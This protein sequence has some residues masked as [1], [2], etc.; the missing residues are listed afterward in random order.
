MT[1][2]ECNINFPD[3]RGFI[4]EFHDGKFYHEDCWKKIINNRNGRNI[5]CPNCRTFGYTTE[6]YNGYPSGLPDSGSVYKAAY[7]KVDCKLCEG[8]GYLEK[9]PQVIIHKEYR[10]A[11]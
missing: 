8:Y 3:N 2:Q 5:N 7:R 9:E 6:E 11:I 4:V 1:C 10:K